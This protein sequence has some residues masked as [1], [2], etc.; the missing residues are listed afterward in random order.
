MY[1]QSDQLYY[2]CS[3][4]GY[5]TGNILLAVSNG[6]FLVTIDGSKITGVLQ[7]KSSAITVHFYTDSTGKLLYVKHSGN[8]NTSLIGGTVTEWS[9]TI[10]G[11]DVST[12]TEL[13]I[14]T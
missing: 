2:L 1:E 7:I 10:S 5:Y 13:T 11:V 6:L 9:Q 3:I 12:L 8:Y 14:T 4:E